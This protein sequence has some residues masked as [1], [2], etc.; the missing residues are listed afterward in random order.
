[1]KKWF[2]SW[3]DI[4]FITLLTFVYVFCIL[5]AWIQNEFLVKSFFVFVPITCVVL[6]CIVLE[7]SVK[8]FK[9][10]NKFPNGKWKVKTLA[11]WLDCL[12]TISVVASYLLLAFG[13][14]FINLM[15]ANICV[16]FLGV[17]LL[18]IVAKIIFIRHTK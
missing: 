16:I 17:H 13:I 1:M 11:F 12:L 15:L 4:L 8:A 10:D 3:E 18:C 2:K 5:I 14:L 6:A 7:S 9:T